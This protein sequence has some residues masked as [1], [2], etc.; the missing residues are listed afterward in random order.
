MLPLSRQSRP[1]LPLLEQFL[2]FFSFVFGLPSFFHLV[3]VNIMP[4]QFFFFGQSLAV[5]HLCSFAPLS[6]QQDFFVFFFCFDLASAT[7]T[8]TFSAAPINCPVIDDQY[9]I[10]ISTS[11]ASFVSSFCSPSSFVCSMTL[12][13]NTN[14]NLLFF[15]FS[16][17]CFPSGADRN[18]ND[19]ELCALWCV[20]VF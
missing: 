18:A 7:G 15:Y 4:G 12:K 10:I 8:D 2:L 9:I 11:L 14:V 19:I 5:D 20:T 13:P 3:Y 17:R 6:G 16:Q 1:F